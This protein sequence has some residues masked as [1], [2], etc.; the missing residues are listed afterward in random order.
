VSDP[1]RVCAENATIV[2]PTYNQAARIVPLLERLSVAL[3]QTHVLVVDNCSQDGTQVRVSQYVK[4]KRA[5]VDLLE[6]RGLTERSLCAT[7]ADAAQHC[8]TAALVLLPPQI[9]KPHTLTNKLLQGLATGAALSIPQRASAE[10]SP[11]FDRIFRRLFKMKYQ[12][13]GLGQFDPFAMALG[14]NTNKTRVLLRSL[15]ALQPQDDFVLL[16]LLSLL[17]PGT[18]ISVVE[19]SERL[20]ELPRFSQQF[21]AFPKTA[22]GLCKLLARS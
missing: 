8:G 21:E 12:K 19:H 1:E 17:E 9:E 13:F 18:E 15:K 14:F 11:Q 22:I 16:H 5:K 7:L 4:L 6:R 2:I 20:K 10:L 3:P